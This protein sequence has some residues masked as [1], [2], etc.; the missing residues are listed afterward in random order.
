MQTTTPLMPKATALWLI[1]N[2]K[3]TFK[4]ISKFCGLHI[5]EVQNLADE[6]STGIVPFDPVAN[7][8]L[9]LS[10]IREAESDT[11]KI[12][13]LNKV[14]E[15]DKKANLKKAKYVPIARRSDRPNAIAWLVKNYPQIPDK[16]I[17]SLLGTTQNMVKS[18]RE[19]TYWNIHTVQPQN[20]VSLYLC[21]Q[22]ELDGLIEKYSKQ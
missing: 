2:T 9:T 1:R 14:V 11:S 19:K 17:I 3:L 20:P 12:L 18:I 5:L 13:Q 6:E 15:I 4:Q 16:D 22:K 10:A 21:N 7:G 8:Q